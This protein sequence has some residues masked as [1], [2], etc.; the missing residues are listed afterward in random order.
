M[1]YFSFK[2]N[3]ENNSNSLIFESGV[4]VE[5]ILINEFEIKEKFTK[6]LETYYFLVHYPMSQIKLH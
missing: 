4:G 1:K 5:T 6:T 2:G 3:L